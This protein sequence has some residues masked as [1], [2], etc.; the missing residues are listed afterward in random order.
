MLAP[1]DGHRIFNI[2]Y[3]AVSYWLPTLLLLTRARFNVLW[4]DLGR[5]NLRAICGIYLLL[6]LLATLYGGTNIF[7]FVSYSVAVQAVVLALLFRQGVGVAETIYVLLVMLLYNKIL[8]DIPMPD[9][10]FD[11]YMNF[12]GGWSSRVNMAS[13]VRFLE[14]GVFVA[15]GASIRMAVAKIPSAGQRGDAAGR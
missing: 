7:I 13:V 4:A 6:V 8:L 14:C 10:D 2:L 11:A 12:Y 5:L 15:I 9:V 3:A 1:L